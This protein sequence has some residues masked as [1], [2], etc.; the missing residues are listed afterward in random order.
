MVGV[1]D[2]GKESALARCSVVGGDGA[3]LYDKHV[4]PNAR[5]TDFRTQFS[6]VR[7]KDLKRE[8]VSLKECQRAVADL[9]DG[10]MLVGHAI[11]NDLKVLLLSHPQ[12]MTRDTAKYKPL[13]R[14]TVRGKHLPR[15]LRELAKQYLGLDIQGGEHSSV[16]DAR[17]A[18]LLYLKHRPS[19]EASIV[20]RRKRRPLRKS[21]KVK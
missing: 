14:K 9:I 12:R 11:H 20:E 5:I 6:G 16:E 8:A 13:M 1:G 2:A 7:P 15:K 19:W 17:A 18:L 4:R 21:S 10:K 3:T